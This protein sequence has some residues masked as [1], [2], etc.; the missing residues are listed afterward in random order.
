MIYQNNP[1][2]ISTAVL[3]AAGTGSRLRALTENLPKCLTQ[4]NEI[5]I[6]GRLVDS[7]HQNGFKR[8]VV[9]VGYLQEHIK[10]YLSENAGDLEVQYVTNKDYSTTNNIYSLWLA[11]DVIN[12]PFM[13]IES[14]LVFEAPMLKGMLI[15]DRIAVS[16]ILP[17][18]NG[19][20]VTTD[21]DIINHVTSINL[22]TQLQVSDNVYKTVNIYSFSMS[23]WRKI[24]TELGKWIEEGK[25]CDY[26]EAVFSEMVALQTL[27]LACVYFDLNKWYE[28]DTIEDLEEC[29]KALDRGRSFTQLTA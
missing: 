24:V 4:V 10:S 17:W 19:T 28:I 6:L 9:V 20:T 16:K 25:V 2:K 22:S 26:Y 27:D 18:M 3:L 13:L 7:L 11:K 21:R 14:D 23:S 8:L 12:E 29:E 5:T 15:P 1:S